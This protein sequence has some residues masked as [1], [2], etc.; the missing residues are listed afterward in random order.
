MS[1]KECDWLKVPMFTSRMIEIGQ[2]T[3]ESLFRS[4]KCGVSKAEIEDMI[5]SY[6][7]AQ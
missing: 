5:R 4:G 1:E 3:I 6:G 7:N 2:L